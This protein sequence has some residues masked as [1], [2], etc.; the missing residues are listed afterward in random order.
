MSFA[1]MDTTSNM[2]S[3]ILH[4]LAQRQDIQCRLREE[5]LEASAGRKQLSY[6][7]LNELPFLDAVCRETLRMYVRFAR[8]RY[9][10]RF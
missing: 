9:S 1:A 5:I 6:D 4:I 3:Q 2:L 7:D 8:S 10:V